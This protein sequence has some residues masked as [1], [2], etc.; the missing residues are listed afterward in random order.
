MARKY[1]VGNRARL[2]PERL[3][4]AR[5]CLFPFRHHLGAL[6]GGKEAGVG[7]AER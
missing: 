6:R 3:P 5:K 1:A 2:Q 7:K 4:L